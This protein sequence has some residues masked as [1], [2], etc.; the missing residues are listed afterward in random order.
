MHSWISF[1]AL[2]V[3]NLQNKKNMGIGRWT[4][5]RFTAGLGVPELFSAAKSGVRTEVVLHKP[6]RI[7]KE[8]KNG[9]VCN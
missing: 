7:S 4:G 8:N 2:M 1:R 5:T 6:R 3:A 9:K